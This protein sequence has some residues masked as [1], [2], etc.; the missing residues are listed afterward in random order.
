MGRQTPVPERE[1]NSIESW[2]PASVFSNLIANSFSPQCDWHLWSSACSVLGE[3]LDWPV[4]QG[5]LRGPSSSREMVQPVRMGP[6]LSH[7]T[8]FKSVGPG[9]GLQAAGHVQHC[10][11]W[12]S[13]A[14]ALTVASEVLQGSPFLLA[15]RCGR[16]WAG[17]WFGNSQWGGVPVR[18]RAQHPVTGRPG[19]PACPLHG[20]PSQFWAPDFLKESQVLD[21]SASGCHSS[22][23][24]PGAARTKRTN[25]SH[26]RGTDWPAVEFCHLPAPDLTASMLAPCDPP[27]ARYSLMIS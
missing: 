21:D 9:R 13:L 15:S 6:S 14:V 17:V 26:C 27:W 11:D 5:C 12:S 23:P 7:P 4:I 10:L 3:G 20:R 22:D 1:E 8:S 2:S 18:G 24:R 19:C 16:S 25:P